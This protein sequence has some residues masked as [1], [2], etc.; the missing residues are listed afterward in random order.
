MLA[1]GQPAHRRTRHLPYIVVYK[2]IIASQ[3]HNLSPEKMAEEKV[4]ICGTTCDQ[5][6]HNSRQNCGKFG[7]IFGE[8][9]S[10]LADRPVRWSENC[11]F[12]IKKGAD[13]VKRTP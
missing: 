8:L 13:R 11:L 1:L 9:A 6:W 10:R 2:T 12:F 3:H 5:Y 4:K 7:T